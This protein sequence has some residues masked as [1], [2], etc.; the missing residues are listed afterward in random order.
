MKSILFICLLLGLVGCSASPHALRGHY[1]M[2]GDSNC[3]SSEART[4]TS[5]YCYNSNG[6]ITGIR[7][8]MSNQELQ[9]YQLKKQQKLSWSEAYE[10]G[11]SR[12]KSNFSDLPSMPTIQSSTPRATAPTY[13]HRNGNS[14][15][16]SDGTNCTI[17]G[18]TLICN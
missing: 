18:N 17:I 7:Y 10:R 2:T 3:M 4:D 8:A 15:L 6:D 9:M 11:K 14:I 16:G 13:Y 1:Y 5:I 12:Y